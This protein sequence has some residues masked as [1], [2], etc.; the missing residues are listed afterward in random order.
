MVGHFGFVAVRSFYN[1]TPA[2]IFWISH[3]GTL[4]GGIG[5]LLKNRSLA[6][7]ALVSIAGHHLFWLIDTLGWMISGQLP[8][9]TTTYLK[10]ASAMDWLQSANHFTTL[11]FLLWVVYR[12]GGVRPN[13]WLWSTAIFAILS[14]ISYFFLPQNEGKH[15]KSE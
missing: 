11:P 9:G 6:S 14:G 4:L 7:I 8:F 3:V 10:E 5:T 13:S 12:L 15:G 2:D 1:E